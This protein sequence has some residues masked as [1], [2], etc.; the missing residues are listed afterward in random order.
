MVIFSPLIFWH[1]ICYC[2][3]GRAFGT[4]F[5]VGCHFGRKRALPAVLADDL[6]FWLLAQDLLMPLWQ[7][8]TGRIGW[9]DHPPIMG[10][11]LG[12]GFFRFP[13]ESFSCRETYFLAS[14]CMLIVRCRLEP[15]R[16]ALRYITRPKRALR[17]EGY[18]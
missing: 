16:D 4:R 15:F 13:V 10:G 3:I 17:E 5:A 1:D 14:S 12:S 6:P 7:V 18:G 11:L 9:Y 8:L 2:H